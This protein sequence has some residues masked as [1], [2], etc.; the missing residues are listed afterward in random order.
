M[1][2]SEDMSSDL[3]WLWVSTYV[4]NGKGIFSSLQSPSVVGRNVCF[5]TTESNACP[6]A[7]GE[8][9][10]KGHELSLISRW[11]C[12]TEHFCDMAHPCDEDSIVVIAHSLHHAQARDESQY[13]EA[14]RDAEECYD[15]SQHCWPTVLHGQRRCVRHDCSRHSS[16]AS[17]R[18]LKGSRV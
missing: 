14:S 4:E 13:D 1:P 17:P 6:I 9:E 10:A 2:G 11:Q 15:H 3:Q 12:L 8:G 7:D 18:M 16:S 5:V